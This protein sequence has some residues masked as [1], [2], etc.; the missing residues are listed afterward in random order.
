MTSFPSTSSS[1]I[2]CP[3]LFL[4]PR[5]RDFGQRFFGQRGF[6]G[7]L[8]D[9]HRPKSD[10]TTRWIPQ[11]NLQNFWRRRIPPLAFG[12]IEPLIPPRMKNADDFHRLPGHFP[13]RTNE[14]ELYNRN[15]LATRYFDY[16]NDEDTVGILKIWTVNERSKRRLLETFSVEISSDGIPIHDSLQS[17]SELKLKMLPPV[18]NEQR[19]PKTKEQL[20]ELRTSIWSP[21][22]FTRLFL[23]SPTLLQMIQLA[24]EDDSEEEESSTEIIGKH[25]PIFHSAVK[26]FSESHLLEGTL[27]VVDYGGRVWIHDYA[28]ETPDQPVKLAAN[29]QE[30]Y[31]FATFCDHPKMIAIAGSY[32]FET[33]DMRSSNTSRACTELWRSPLFETRRRDEALYIQS[34]PPVSSAIRHV[35]RVPETANNYLVMTDRALHLI[36]DRFPGKTVLSVEHPFSTGTHKMIVSE[37]MKDPVDGGNVISIFCLDQLQV[38]NSSISMTKLYSHPS[39]VWSSVDAF[40]SMGEPENFNQVVRRGKYADPEVLSEP[41]RAM[42]LVE[43]RNWK[44]SLLLRQTDDGAIWWQ[45]FSNEAAS[46]QEIVEEERKSLE[47]IIEKRNIDPDSWKREEFRPVYS[48]GMVETAKET[49][50]DLRHVIHVGSPSID[51]RVI[52]KFYHR[53]A[54]LQ[55]QAARFNITQHPNHLDVLPLDDVNSV[56]SKIT[57]DTWQ[58]FETLTNENRKV[59]GFRGSHSCEGSEYDEANL[60]QTYSAL[61]SLAILGDDLKRVDRKAILKTV[62]ESQRDNGCFWSQGVGSESDMRFVFCAVAIC[63]ILDGEKEDIID[64]ERLSSFLKKSL[65]IDGGIGQAPGDESHGG[66]TFCAVASLALANRLWTEEVLSRRDID[67]LIRWAIQKQHVG[68]HGRAHKPDDSCYAFWIGATLKILNAYHLISKPHLREFLMISQHMHIGGF[69]K[70]PEPGGYSDIL[71]TYF[72]IAALS[73]LGEPALNPVHPSLNVSMR[74]ADHIARIRFK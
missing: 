49:P 33:V 35:A 74:A 73:L 15:L 39:G 47:R 70:Y 44:S 68:F 56:L 37:N 14:F 58:A 21:R 22:S 72:S 43:H 46:E 31:Q 55:R 13:Y 1:P 50:A 71:H 8:E 51:R 48:D 54:N 40:H 17:V 69:C 59:C 18:K 61:L 30:I 65:N 26:S 23:R 27:A 24:E 57:L 25:I 12:L 45:K 20:L 41:T 10:G 64:W 66:S 32:H 19:P 28:S 63:K 52:S 4:E 9:F 60:A 6:G 36:D 29:D 42:A 11:Y 38:L 62:K 2:P 3:A 34:V 5:P 16:N 67:R 7:L 53:A